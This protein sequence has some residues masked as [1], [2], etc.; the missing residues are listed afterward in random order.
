M[1]EYNSIP[2]RTPRK[3]IIVNRVPSKNDLM[4][5]VALNWVS[6]GADIVTFEFS[7]SLSEI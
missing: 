7:V 3:I 6:R 2:E 5:L 4:K 1:S